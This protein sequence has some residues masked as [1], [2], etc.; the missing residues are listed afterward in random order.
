MAVG[1]PARQWERTHPEIYHVDM[2]T[3]KIT[4]QQHDSTYHCI[5]MA[6]FLNSNATS[7]MH[8]F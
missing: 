2:C 6:Y 1:G 4:D 8:L 5:I 7:H 3:G